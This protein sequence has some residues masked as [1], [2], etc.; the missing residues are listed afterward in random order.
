MATNR[1]D[2]PTQPQAVTWIISPDVASSVN[3][4]IESKMEHNGKGKI[5]IVSPMSLSDYET[6][7]DKERN[8]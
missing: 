4:G 2:N 3:L 5:T 8:Y 1:S 6:N 7:N